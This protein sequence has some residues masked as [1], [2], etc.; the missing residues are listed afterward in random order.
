MLATANA[1]DAIVRLAPIWSGAT[2]VRSTVV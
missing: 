1:R 2:M